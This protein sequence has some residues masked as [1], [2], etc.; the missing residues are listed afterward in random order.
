MVTF[1]RK[2]LRRIFGQKINALGDFELRTNREVEELYGETNIIG[3]LKSSRLGWTSYWWKDRIKKDA[4]RLG[5]NDGK[6]LAQDRD[7][8]RPVVVAAIDLNG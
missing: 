3:V 2:V 4:L 1:E 5:V 7:R 8:L 6:E